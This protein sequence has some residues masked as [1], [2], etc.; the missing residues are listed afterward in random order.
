MFVYRNRRTVC[1]WHQNRFGGA[2]KRFVLVRLLG[3]GGQIDGVLRFSFGSV[4]RSHWSLFGEPNIVSERLAIDRCR[5]SARQE[6][7]W[8]LVFRQK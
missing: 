1:G 4:P 3:G 7:K 2:F 8:F 5:L 6:I